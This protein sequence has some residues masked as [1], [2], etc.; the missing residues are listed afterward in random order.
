[1]NVRM[2]IASLSEIALFLVASLAA[3]QGTPIAIGKNGDVELTKPARI[4][5]TRL[6][7][8][9]YRLQHQMQ[10]DEHFLVVKARRKEWRGSRM[11]AT[12]SGTEVARVP[13]QVV[14]QD[15]KGKGTRL[16]VRAEADGSDTITQIWIRGERGGHVVTL[17]PQAP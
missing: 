16:H 1:M 6:E 3:A 7:P 11:E 17:Q 2:K 10:N 8:G 14:P 4:G 13:C 9:F 5:T 12:G 15:S